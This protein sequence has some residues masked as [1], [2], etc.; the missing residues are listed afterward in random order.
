M[1]VGVVTDVRGF[2]IACDSAICLWNQRFVMLCVI[3]VWEWT[4]FPC[5]PETQWWLCFYAI[6]AWNLVLLIVS[7]YWT[8][9]R[10][11]DAFWWVENVNKKRKFDLCVT[12]WFIQM[13]HLLYKNKTCPS[14]IGL[15][16]DQEMQA[17]QDKPSSFPWA[18]FRSHALKQTKN[19]R[20][21]WDR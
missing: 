8:L 5:A 16:L 18:R 15:I 13:M 12:S 10:F 14:V 20:R 4:R 11:Q 7:V 6:Q 2:M 1:A 17:N 9:G 19:S 21:Q 3:T